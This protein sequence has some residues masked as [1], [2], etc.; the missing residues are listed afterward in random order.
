[1]VRLGVA[2]VE[3]WRAPGNPGLW[4]LI[5]QRFASVPVDPSHPPTKIG[6]T[7]IASLSAGNRTRYPFQNR[8][9]YLSHK[10]AV[11]QNRPS[12]RV[13]GAGLHGGPALALTP[14]TAVW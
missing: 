9:W 3:R 14:G 10:D 13:V 6:T 4:G 2:G 1:M 12:I 11:G 8:F 5:D 7:V